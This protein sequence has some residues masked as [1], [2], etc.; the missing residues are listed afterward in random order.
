M[1]SAKSVAVASALLWGGG[2]LI[3]G[4]IHLA[5]PAYAADFL[6]L[7]SSV[8]PGYHASR[9]LADALIGGAYGAVDGALGGLFFAWLY[10][11]FA[12]RARQP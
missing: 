1:L 8:Y 10:N 3:L 2:I 12:R 4:L 6:R 7:I 5:A 11:L 9:S